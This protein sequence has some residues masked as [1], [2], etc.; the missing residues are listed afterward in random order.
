MLI[1]YIAIPIVSFLAIIGINIIPKYKKINKTLKEIIND[2]CVVLFIESI[3]DIFLN[4]TKCGWWISF[5]IGCAIFF[6]LYFLF[7]KTPLYKKQTR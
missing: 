2:I 7:T 3:K 4:Y 5:G 1:L 6:L